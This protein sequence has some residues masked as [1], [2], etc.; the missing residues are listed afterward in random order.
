MQRAQNII[1][2]PKIEI[3]LVKFSLLPPNIVFTFST[4]LDVKLSP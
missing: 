4:F 3:I 2:A 1:G